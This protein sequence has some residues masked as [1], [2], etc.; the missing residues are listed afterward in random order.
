MM[1]AL[2]KGTLRFEETFLGIE[3]GSTGIKAALIDSAH[4]QIASGSY[5]WETVWKTDFGRIHSKISGK[6]FGIVIRNF[7]RM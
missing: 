2:H 6:G 5:V 7:P 4:H 3:L 1:G